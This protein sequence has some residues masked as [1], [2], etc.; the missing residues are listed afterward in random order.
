MK[1]K[2]II[3]TI[4]ISITIIIL[5]LIMYLQ[6]YN[7]TANT[8]KE[9]T[10]NQ[11]KY[12]NKVLPTIPVK[13]TT[14]LSN[15]KI[16]KQKDIQMKKNKLIDSQNIK[17]LKST[18][19][20]IAQKKINK[21]CYLESNFATKYATTNKYNNIYEKFINSTMTSAN[22]VVGKNKYKRNVK[23]I[24]KDGITIIVCEK[25]ISKEYLE[26]VLITLDKL[27]KKISKTLANNKTYIFIVDFYSKTDIKRN[28]N[29][30]VYGCTNSINKIWIYNPNDYKKFKGSISET[31]FHEIGHIID[32]QNS[33]S[34]NYAYKE[35]M[36]ED[37]KLSN[38]ILSKYALKSEGKYKKF[39]HYE[40]F[41]ETFAFYFK[42]K[43]YLKN[44]F[45]NRTK[46]IENFIE[47]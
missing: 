30:F 1:L 24:I 3:K 12:I 34:N 17:K 11:K 44:F 21:K 13:T 6:S 33:L 32:N 39:P 2:K 4:G 19:T 46:F 14:T 9:N 43:N 23:Q 35:A 37:S 5:L 42:N 40:D 20:K 28:D 22:F 7:I 41:A 18:N 26:Q 16:S 15:K 8:I 25:V 38:Y 10:V 29:H 27:P 47:S 31:L 45:P 36:D